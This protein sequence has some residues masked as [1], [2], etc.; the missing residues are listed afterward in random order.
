M[1]QV[2]INTL[3]SAS[4]YA[5]LA[6]SFS[7]IFSTARF[8]HFAHGIIF[9]AGAYF[10]FLYKACLA[11]P[12][13]FSIVFAVVSSVVLGCIVDVSIYRPLRRI[14]A[15]PLIFLLAS[16]GVYIILQNVISM[17]FGDDTK[18]IRAGVVV[19]GVSIFGARITPIQIITICVSIT[20]ILAVVFALKTMKMG[21]AM[22]AVANDPE[23]ASISGIRSDK[24]ILW[25]FAIGSAL[26]S[27]TGILVAFDV[28]M[29]PSMGMNALMMGIVVIFIGGI[30]SITG[31]VLGALLLSMVQNLGV[32]WIASQWQDAIAFA[33]LFAFLLLRPQGFL[34]RKVRK[35]TV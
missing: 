11:L 30:G 6:L 3:I 13:S 16:F 29:T 5:L 34:G 25:A 27:I 4:V 20:L 35:V 15:S 32:W 18:T 7:L 21:I 14:V 28:D 19:E 12:L 9:T 26:A 23:L 10:C 2:I 33:I 31:I 22:R 24:V 17:F 1:P 8:F